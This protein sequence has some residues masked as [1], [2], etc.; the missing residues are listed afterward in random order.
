MSTLSELAAQQEDRIH[1]RE[2]KLQESL[3]KMDAL[4][5]RNWR[6]LLGGFGETAAGPSLEQVHEASV[7]AREMM[8]LN[9]H[10]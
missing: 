10:V 7:R 3:D 8:A 5:D 2:Y 1:D 6:P 9:V 4:F